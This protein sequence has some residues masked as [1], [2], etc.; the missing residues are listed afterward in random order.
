MSDEYSKTILIKK[1]LNKYKLVQ[2]QFTKNSNDIANY[3]LKDKIL[4]LSNGKKLILNFDKITDI[5]GIRLEL[6]NPYELYKIN[7][8]IWRG[9][10]YQKKI[11]FVLDYD[12]KKF[13]FSS[14]MRSYSSS[15][16]IDLYQ[17]DQN[18]I[19]NLIFSLEKIKKNKFKLDC[20]NNING[21]DIDL[22]VFSLILTSLVFNKF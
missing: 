17:T 1:I 7:G 21:L 3:L 11:H 8:Y 6:I 12:N 14:K 2:I 10:F 9:H 4:T 18:K 5:D 19:S 22:E 16:N 20:I 13:F 15:K